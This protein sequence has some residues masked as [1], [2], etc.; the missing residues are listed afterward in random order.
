MYTNLVEFDG[1]NWNVHKPPISDRPFYIYEIA[2]DEAGKKWLATN[3]GLITFDGSNWTMCD[4]LNSRL[5][6]TNVF[7]VVIDDDGRKW[8]GTDHGLAV[9][10]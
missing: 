7:A 4:E 9:F 10:D 8:V 6:S 5:Q 1:N 2:I 3:H